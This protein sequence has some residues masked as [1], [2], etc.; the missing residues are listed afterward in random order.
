VDALRVGAEVIVCPT[1]VHPGSALLLLVVTPE[2][3]TPNSWKAN[4]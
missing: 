3:E 4:Q 2:R 1:D